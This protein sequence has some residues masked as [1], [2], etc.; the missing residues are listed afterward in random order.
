MNRPAVT[1]H[2]LPLATLA[3]VVV[4]DLLI[5]REQVLISLV[6]I[7]P[8][9]AATALG[10]RATAGYGVAAV[11]TAAVL[12]V[13]DQQYTETTVVAQIARIVGVTAGG[14]AAVAACTL[15][16]RR[17]AQTRRLVAEQAADRAVLELA[18]TLQRSLLTEPPTLERLTTA[19]RYRPATVGAHVGGDWYDAFAVPDG[20]TMLVIGDVE[21]HDARAA[22]TM[23][24]ARGMLRGLAQSVVGSPAAVLSALDRALLDLDVEALVTITVAT[25]DERAP[26]GAVELRWSNAGHPPPV[27]VGADGSAGLLARPVDRL[28]GLDEA[29]PRYDHELLLTPGDTLLLYTDGLVERR[30]APLDDGLA[31]LVDRLR[32]SSARPLEDVCDSLVAELGGQADDDVAVMALR[33]R[34]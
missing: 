7:A 27:L 4:T 25:L 32:G 31:S 10:R 20:T 29:G 23:A 6:A 22:A 18:E 1:A 9:V 15:R 21:G 26:A 5:G 16:Q 28:L 34:V 24:Q 33:V 13:Y 12:G 30:D 17:E 3:A 19:V 2:A 8:M 14:V 11:V